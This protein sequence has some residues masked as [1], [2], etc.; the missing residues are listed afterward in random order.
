MSQIKRCNP[1]LN[2]SAD[3]PAISYDEPT[4]IYCGRSYSEWRMPN[5]RVEVEIYPPANNRRKRTRRDY[6]RDRDRNN[7]S[8]NDYREKF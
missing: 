2:K 5:G 3:N 6:D 1:R 8:D 7:D 4:P